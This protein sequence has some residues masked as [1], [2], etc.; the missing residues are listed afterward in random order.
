M[1]EKYAQNDEGVC[2]EYDMNSIVLNIKQNLR[3]FP[4]RYV[5]DRS[6]TQDI[7]FDSSDYNDT[8]GAYQQAAKKYMLSCLTKNKVPYAQEYEWQLMCEHI[9]LEAGKT[10]MLF[11]FILPSK[12][13]LGSNISKN[14]TFE[15]AITKCA[16]GKT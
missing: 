13:I 1:W 6:N 5:D 12:I 15:S 7:C 8:D 9:E 4:I 3:F 16:E 10:G 14:P 11:D 2:F